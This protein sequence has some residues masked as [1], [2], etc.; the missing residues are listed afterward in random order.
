MATDEFYVDEFPKEQKDDWVKESDDG[1]GT[2][3]GGGSGTG[4]ESGGVGGGS[5]SPDTPN[6]EDYDDQNE[7]HPLAN[8][9]SDGSF[10]PLVDG[11]GVLLTHQGAI[12]ESIAGCIQFIIECKIKDD[13]EGKHLRCIIIELVQLK[14][15]KS[16]TVI[17]GSL[18]NGRIEVRAKWQRGHY[19]YADVSRVKF[20]LQDQKKST[21]W[22]KL[23]HSTDDGVAVMVLTVF[24]GIISVEKFCN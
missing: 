14:G 13:S 17:K 21:E 9:N 4:G 19:N 22:I 2:G 7:W 18:P 23:P 16:Q 5:W 24:N 15:K 8:L 20:R 3:G 11:S 6:K 12:L 10:L 1:T